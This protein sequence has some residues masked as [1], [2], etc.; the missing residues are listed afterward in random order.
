MM[1][2]SYFTIKR[3]DRLRFFV[4]FLLASKRHRLQSRF[5]SNSGVRSNREYGQKVIYVHFRTD[6]I[7]H[8]FIMRDVHKV[9]VSCL[10]YIPKTLLS[11][12]SVIC[13]YCRKAEGFL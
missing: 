2:D 12:F 7:F 10:S 9:N 6:R 3:R 5:T 8:M 4:V 11:V 1:T 13:R